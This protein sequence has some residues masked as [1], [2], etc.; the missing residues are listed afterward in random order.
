VPEAAVRPLSRYDLRGELGRGGTGIVYEAFDLRTESLVAL[1]TIAAAGPE[2]LYRLKREF[3]ALADVQHPNLVRLGELSSEEG[4]WYFTMEIVHG[5]NFIDYVRP[6]SRGPA[7][8]QS[9]LDEGRLRAVLPQLVSA[10]GAIHE[11][12]HLHR[13]VKPSNVL[14]TND[15]RLVLLDFGLVTALRSA[16]SA[17]DDSFEGTPTFMAPEQI[18][19]LSVGPPAD[20]YAMGIMMFLALTG[21]L[22]F[23]GT[24]NEILEAKLLAQ[25][26]PSPR[27]L[28]PD[29][30]RD[31]DELC[32]AL[33]RLEP[34]Q[35]P[36]VTEIRARLGM[37][38]DE[39]SSGG[40]RAAEAVFVGRELELGTLDQALA[41]VER[42]RSR[43]VV[44]EGEPGVG[45]SAL[46]NR[47]LGSVGSRAIVLQGRCY[48]QETVPFKGID[49]ILDA[50]SEHLLALSSDET[51]RVIA[52]GVGYL[53]A[54]FPVLK[55]VPVVGKATTGDR[56]VGNASA[57][58]E[59][60]FGEFER[61]L[62][63]L[64]V[65]LPVV[66]FVD[67]LQWA[68]RD[69]QALLQRA[70]LGGAACLFVATMRPGA[71][72]DAVPLAAQ[73]E[74]IALGGLSADESRTLWNALSSGAAQT[75]ASEDRRDAAMREAAGHP[76]FLAELA[77]SARDH[78]PNLRGGA[79]LLDVLWGRVQERD[80]VDRGLL[81]VV[82]VAG[83]PLPDT[84]LAR[85]ADVPLGDV[86]TRLGPLRAAQ[87]VRVVRR[88]DERLVEPYHDRLRESIVLRLQQGAAASLE[89]RHLAIGRALLDGASG[90]L[91]ALRVFAIVQHLNAATGA[92][93]DARERAHLAALNGLA[94]KQ[95]RLATAYD[96]AREYARVGLELAGDAGWS[97]AYDVTRDLHVERMQAEFLAGNVDE[98]RACFEEA[99]ARVTSDED[100]TDLHASWIELL[101][102]EGRYR[103]AI[104]AGRVALDTLSAP[105]PARVGT[106][107]VLAR[108]VSTRLVQGRRR[109][110]AL[111]HLPLLRDP[112]LQGVMRLLMS[113]A[114][115]A[116]FSDTKLLTWIL[117]RIAGLSMRFGVSNVSSYG[118]GGY[119]LVLSAAFGN[120]E[121]GA[122]FAQFAL[123]LNERFQNLA[124]TSKLQM[125]AG[126]LVPW[127][128]PFADAKEHLRSGYDVALK[129]G[130][131]TYECYCA[132]VHSIVS[133]CEST[134]LAAVQS[135]AEWA[136]DVSVRRKE[137]A[138]IGVP[139]AHA[140][141]AATL[142]GLT[143]SVLDLGTAES[144]D[145]DFRASLSDSATPTALFYYQFCTADLAYHF[146]N[147]AAARALLR[148]AEKR[149]EGIFGLP[150]TVEL[151]FLDA[152]VAAREHDL[153]GTSWRKRL[154][155]RLRV[156]GALRKL[157]AWAASCP[158]NF[159][160]HALIVEAEHARIRG[161]R[162]RA[163]ECFER[164]IATAR[165]RGSPRREALALE[166]A[167]AHAL[168]AGETAKAAQ[169][170]AE[171]IAAYRRWG[172][173]AKADALEER[174]LRAN[175]APHV[176][177]ARTSTNQPSGGT[178][179]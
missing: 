80:G 157:R 86:V 144:P 67:D 25:E 57:L 34:S 74:R 123:A 133:F 4:L 31:L 83:A 172:A 77:R 68:D 126:M 147:A 105:V 145:S 90:D 30:P 165:V 15:G 9:P 125:I 75:S 139:E 160:A 97:R 148:E 82:A 12:G 142:R 150:T 69:S 52:G 141:H 8:A 137:R 14:V 174:T 146:G 24:F 176:A 11:A 101:T 44:V 78:G 178:E 62:R 79:R 131:T 164:A 46:V 49:A 3:R 153:A 91:L 19:A 26:A 122:A 140:R 61:L 17:P 5:A 89:A 16:E 23:D 76:L 65:R 71:P 154:G 112:R 135:D 179:R 130:D 45:K 99:R 55:R 95:A 120:R 104:D 119:G 156:Y 56:P 109:I 29:T 106:A 129:I 171:A 85:A 93:K 73:A 64:S 175:D 50:L 28:S 151:A 94:A 155:L 54:V 20:W 10:L 2:N 98:A 38:V 51:H 115:A 88:E 66:L 40:L 103:D 58:R 108:Y 39:Q 116:F 149:T 22:P 161:K 35:R 168:A 166:R 177:H 138:M 59:Q 114:P 63:E 110:E 27:K 159:A 81:E 128:R 152:L 117:L 118:F 47:F 102:G 132:V 124:L 113:L 92:R 60:A 169:R 173:S 162:A 87:L 84:V 1:K 134:D 163:D 136:R 6:P 158:A 32:S 111:L 70:L 41:E 7:G 170:R 72:P 33:L 21:R 143:P 13:D 37:R 42:G 36:D 18:E 53:A 96:R 48:E 100:R 107:G 167:A 127:V 121:E 43:T